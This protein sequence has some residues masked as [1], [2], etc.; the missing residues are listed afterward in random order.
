MPQ[1]ISVSQGK[2]ITINGEPDVACLKHIRPVSRCDQAMP[3][4]YPR[5]QEVPLCRVPLGGIEEVQMIA[6]GQTK[7]DKV[8][9]TSTYYCL[10]IRAVL[11]ISAFSRLEIVAAIN[12]QNR[13]VLAS[14]DILRSATRA[15]AH[16]HSLRT[17]R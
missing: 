8:I 12:S 16:F 2:T 10:D 3:A 11:F 5:V 7:D 6:K 9:Q 14:H 13:T 15:L 1:E 17:R 4:N